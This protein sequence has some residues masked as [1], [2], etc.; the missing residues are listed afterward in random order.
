M[1]DNSSNQERMST[2][3]IN[4]IDEPCMMKDIFLA[5]DLT[6]MMTNNSH[7]HMYDDNILDIGISYYISGEGMV[8]LLL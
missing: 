3:V 7:G 6:T 1:K 2:C 5:G 8:H 4:V